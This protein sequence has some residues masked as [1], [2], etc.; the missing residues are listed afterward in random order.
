MSIEEI[1]AKG[2]LG[3]KER[4]PTFK[5]DIDPV[6]D[7]NPIVDVV[8][9]SDE[10]DDEED[11]VPIST[12]GLLLDEDFDDEDEGGDLISDGTIVINE[13]AV[14]ETVSVQTVG[15]NNDFQNG[16]S[17]G[18]NVNVAIAAGDVSGP[19]AHTAGSV[20]IKVGSSSSS[21]LSEEKAAHVAPVVQPVEDHDHGFFHVTEAVVETVP[22]PVPAPVEEIVAPKKEIEMA[23]MAQIPPAGTV[24]GSGST[25]KEN[26]LWPDDATHEYIAR[27]RE[28]DPLD[29][30][31]VEEL[32]DIEPN[33]DTGKSALALAADTDTDTDTDTET[34][35]PTSTSM[36]GPTVSYAKQG[37]RKIKDCA[38]AKFTSSAANLCPRPL[39]GAPTTDAN[40][41]KF[42]RVWDVC[43]DQCADYRTDDP[44]APTRT[45]IKTKTGTK[46]KEQE[47]FDTSRPPVIV[48]DAPKAPSS[49]TT[50]ANDTYEYVTAEE[51]AQE[52]S[53]VLEKCGREGYASNSRSNSADA[54]DFTANPCVR[55]EPTFVGCTDANLFSA[56]INPFDNTVVKTTVA[57]NYDLYMR[58]DAEVEQALEQLEESMLYHVAGGMDFDRCGADD[59]ERRLFA[60][61]VEEEEEDGQPENEK[62]SISLVGLSS[63]PID[64]RDPTYRQCTSSLQST[65][66]LSINDWRSIDDEADAETKCVPMRGKMTLYL[67]SKDDRFAAKHIVK[68]MVKAG[69]EDGS[70]LSSTDIRGV[71]YVENRALD[72]ARMPGNNLGQ[73]KANAGVR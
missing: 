30:A 45:K 69:A 43:C 59:G 72:A 54:D 22:V 18:T 37:I 62:N 61:E 49:T 32:E 56:S 65:S 58:S 55:S 8:P 48:L 9:L 66:S 13:P 63:Q 10:E 36:C 2:I 16:G 5:L 34:S 33:G 44:I 27:P 28:I 11:A 47:Q 38:S 26:V 35:T 4:A 31:D 3:L 68:S 41:G 29:D 40:S 71:A 20:V 50:T 1:A 7:V 67:S 73:F 51:Y 12:D 15:S 6:V 64:V 60:E 70:F 21:T 46:Q 25:E 42:L 24:A 17:S 14:V 52:F 53:I 57:Y 39:W 19:D 23:E